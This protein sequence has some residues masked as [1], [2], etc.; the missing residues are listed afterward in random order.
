MA[1]YNGAFFMLLCSFSSFGA[2]ATLNLRTG[3]EGQTCF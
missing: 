3:E 1:G 2:R